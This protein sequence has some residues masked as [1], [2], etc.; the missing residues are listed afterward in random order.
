MFNFYQCFEKFVNLKTNFLWNQT[1]FV[2]MLILEVYGA[3]ILSKYYGISF[4]IHET[5]IIYT[6]ILRFMTKRQK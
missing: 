2:G 6:I 3:Y 4:D 5:Q 1:L